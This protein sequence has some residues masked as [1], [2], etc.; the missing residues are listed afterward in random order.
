M[1]VQALRNA[2]RRA[3]KEN[4]SHRRLTDTELIRSVIG[5]SVSEKQISQL[6]SQMERRSFKARQ[7]VVVLGDVA[8]EVLLLASGKI[9]VLGAKESVLAEGAFVGNC[10]PASKTLQ[11]STALAVNKATCLVISKKEVLEGKSKVF[12]L[13]RRAMLKSVVESAGIDWMH[14]MDSHKQGAIAEAWE[15]CSLSA[16]EY[17]FKNGAP[18]TMALLMEGEGELVG[19]EGPPP[20]VNRGRR[21]SLPAVDQPE[22]VGAH[23]P[24][25]PTLPAMH[26]AFVLEALQQSE[27]AGASGPHGDGGGARRQ[28]VGSVVASSARGGRQRRD[29]MKQKGLMKT[30]PAGGFEQLRRSTRFSMDLL[31]L[32]RAQSNED[33]P[34]PGTTMALETPRLLYGDPLAASFRMQGESGAGGPSGGIGPRSKS[35]GNLIALQKQLTAGALD[36]SD[37]SSLAS[38]SPEDEEKKEKGEELE[39]KGKAGSGFPSPSGRGGHTGC[40]RKMEPGELYGAEFFL[41]DLVRTQ[42]VEKVAHAKYEKGENVVVEGEVADDLFFI[43][44][45]RVRVS[46]GGK[47]VRYVGKFD[48]FGERPLL[49]KEKNTARLRT[50]T[51]TAE[52][53]TVCLVLGYRDFEE[54]L[55]GLDSLF[56][57]RTE[58]Q[59]LKVEDLAINNKL[60]EGSYGAVFSVK[61]KAEASKSQT[62]KSQMQLALKTIQ[63]QGLDRGARKAVLLERDRLMENWHPCVLTG[64]ATVRGAHFLFFVS[65]LLQGGDLFSAIRE[66][67]HLTG[68]QSRFFAAS[69]ALGLE[70]IHDSGY[71]YRDLK[72][73][74]VMLDGEGFVK[75]VD[76][77]TCKRTAR[78]YTLVG[79]P[80]YLAPEV[81][82]GKGY[83][84]GVDWWALGVCIYEFVC[85]PLPFGYKCEG[86]LDLFKEILYKP[87]D[88]PAHVLDEPAKAV[89][90]RLLEKSPAV[91][92]NSAE[93][94]KAQPFFEPVNWQAILSRSIS[95]P[96]VPSVDETAKGQGEPRIASKGQIM[97]D[98]KR[99]AE[100]RA[101][102]DVSQSVSQSDSAA[103]AQERKGKETKLDSNAPPP[104]SGD[105][106]SPT[107]SSPSSGDPCSSTTPPPSLGD[108]CSSSAPPPSSGA[109]CSSTTT[110]PTVRKH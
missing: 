41:R 53:D 96:F 51:C 77:G 98:L 43:Y 72:P 75:L 8:T 64:V 107:T 92:L 49:N 108:P 38:S 97:Q 99:A 66:I 50:A 106:C 103:A 26:P 87:L 110:T 101:P 71:L 81:I 36:T 40:E 33:N 59:D 47:H 4:A 95:P 45:G 74:N 37:I 28:S 12:Q 86:H 42:M 70:Y 93:E 88:F 109:S 104:S 5:K 73:E 10:S 17:I 80:E 79:T 105:P 84:K 78:T 63:R 56:R 44:S 89:M 65:E 54:V 25:A 85:G 68:E 57:E 62:G 16:G 19:V 6:L 52:E 46:K 102:E 30:M 15:I 58:L 94:V 21:V 3:D 2:L 55:S 91:R 13:F 29:E 39:V 76:F 31:P 60:G 7:E 34:N 82:M 83:G 9:A 48:Y 14:F 20:A 32:S 23:A 35:M 22:A 100:L 18:P 69:I 61:S 1:Y 24:H 90:S 27:A 11:T 67:G